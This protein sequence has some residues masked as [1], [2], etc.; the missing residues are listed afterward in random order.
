[1]TLFFEGPP[2][3]NSGA[4]GD[5]AATPTAAADD[6]SSPEMGEV[7]L[8]TAPQD[9]RFPTANQVTAHRSLLCRITRRQDTRF[10]AEVLWSLLAIVH[11]ALL[12]TLCC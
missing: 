1:M 3:A 6:N 5:G 2:L 11:V 8:R 4:A 7:T 9:A 12:F 10:V